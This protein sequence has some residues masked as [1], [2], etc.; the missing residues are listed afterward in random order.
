MNSEETR[1][2]QQLQALYLSF[3][4]E[5]YPGLDRAAARQQW[6]PV[7]HLARLIEGETQ[8]R[9][10]RQIV[11]RVAAAR[12]PVLKTLEQFNWTWPKKVNQDQ[13]RTSSAW[14][15]S[16]TNQRHLRRRRRLGHYAGNRIMPG[17]GLAP[18]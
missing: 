11:R 10:D 4:V 6:T 2:T 14:P 8:R 9:H 16:K 15:S 18:E 1:L 17:G 7:Q 12:F 5:H 13:G 3:M